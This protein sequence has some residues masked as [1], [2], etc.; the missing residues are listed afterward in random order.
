MLSTLFDTGYLLITV[1][2]L[3]FFLAHSNTSKGYTLEIMRWVIFGGIFNFISFTWLYTVYPLTWL[4]AGFLQMS[5]IIILHLVLS[6]ISGFCFFIVGIV[7]QKTRDT[8]KH[9]RPT[10]IALSFVIAEIMRSLSISFLY[11][12]KGTSIDL[13]FNAGTIG[14]ALSVTP[15]VEL[16]YFGG[17]FA[18]TFFLTYVIFTLVSLNKKGS[19]LHLGGVIIIFFALHFLVPVRAPKHTVSVG[20][21]TTA[22]S[23]YD[24]TEY[25]R[26]AEATNK[27]I[28][29]ILRDDA[30][31]K[32]VIVVPEDTRFLKS[33]SEE[34]KGVLILQHNNTL[35]VDG[36]TSRTE[37]GLA[38]MSVFFETGSGSL[39]WRGKDFLLPF[40]EYIPF[41]FE[42]VFFVLIGEKITSYQQ[43]HTYTPIPS[44]KTVLSNNIR[45]GTLI[46]SE[47][48]SHRTISRLK[49]EKPDIVLFQSRLNVFNGNPLFL[50]HLRSFSKVAAAQ[51]RTPLLSSTN[52]A[53]SYLL[54]GRGSI[55][56]IIPTSLSYSSVDVT[57]GGE[58]ILK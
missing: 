27:K 48:M 11:L 47:I 50:M 26:E 36:D 35:F 41:I 40:N 37:E 15:F 19:A 8:N 31:K 55:V 22:G 58:V 28:L 49:N 44:G 25:I 13:H 14:N 6:L 33:L 32:D 39:L 18:L 43:K 5:G 45:V 46:C 3:W 52:S 38:N 12:G 7:I 16:A 54:S 53:P 2:L 17:T 9:I 29:Q 24:D 34:E 30:T 21:M 42:R 56:E 20:I 57:Q 4:P 10:F 23:A 1:L 51:L